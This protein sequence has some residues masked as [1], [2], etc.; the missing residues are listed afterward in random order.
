MG[1]YGCNVCNEEY[2]ALDEKRTPRVLTGC[3]HTICQGCAQ[4]ICK[5]GVSHIICPFDRVSTPVA[6]GKL[7]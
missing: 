2:S 1:E 7:L 5:P 3:G 6:R 4:A